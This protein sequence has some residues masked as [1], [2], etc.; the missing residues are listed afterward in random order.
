MIR[1]QNLG[2]YYKLR[3]SW[4]WAVPSSD[5]A[6]LVSFLTY[7]NIQTILIARDWSSI[8]NWGCLHITKENGLSSIPAK[9]N[10]VDFHLQINLG[11]L[12]FSQNLGRLSFKKK[13]GSFNAVI[14]KLAHR[15]GGHCSCHCF[16]GPSGLRV[17][18]QN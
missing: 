18:S 15:N 6:M 14:A 13:I 9:K 11:H 16:F 8:R 7:P 3:T 17:L 12:Q 10:K 5:Q 1:N 2:S 4:G